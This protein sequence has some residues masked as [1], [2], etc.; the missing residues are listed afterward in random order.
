MV[1]GNRGKVAAALLVAGIDLAGTV[2]SRVRQRA[3]DTVVVNGFG[4]SE[5]WFGGYPAMPA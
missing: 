5:T 3:G 2:G 4:L 1:S